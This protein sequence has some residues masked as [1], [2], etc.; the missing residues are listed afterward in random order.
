MANTKELQENLRPEYLRLYNVI[1][2]ENVNISP[3]FTVLP[4]RKDYPDYYDVIKKPIS[5]NTLKKRLTTYTNAQQFMDDLVHIPWNA[6]VYN[7]KESEIYKYALTLEKFINETVYPNL[8]KKY[9]KL[10][11][12]YLGPTPDEP[13]YQEFQEKLLIKEKEKQEE[14]E[15]KERLEK[16]AKS[17]KVLIRTRKTSNKEGYTTDS[18]DSNNE[19]HTETG[20]D[21]HYTDYGKGDDDDEYT[22]SG[23][24]YKQ[25]RVHAKFSP[26]P[27]GTPHPLGL[28]HSEKPVKK[29]V[30]RGRPPII[31][32]PYVQRMKNVLK[33]I[34]KEV[35]ERRRSL[36]DSFEK[37]P[38][39]NYNPQYYSI[40]SNPISL[41]EIRKKVKTRKYKDFE[42]FHNDIKL[43]LSNYRTYN[44]NNPN[45]LKRS[46][47]FEKSFNELAQFELSRPDT[48]YMPEGEFRC[49]LDE[50][51]VN[52]IT[53]QVGDWVL[54]KNRNDESKPIVGQI[55]KFWSEGTSGTKWL[56]AC[57][58]YRPEQ[59]VHRVDRLFYKTEVVK[60]GQYRDHKVS[61]IQGKCY[62]V[63]F[64]RYQRGDP[65]INIDGPLFVCEYRYN[66]SD[67]AFNKIRT[68]RAC[69]PEEIRDVEEQTIPVTGR[70][71]FKFPSPIRHLLPPNSTTRDP[72]PDPT[73]GVPNAPPI[74]GG[75]YMR[76]KLD[77]DDLGEYST[78]DDCPKHIIRPNDPK[79]RLEGKIDNDMGTIIVSGGMGNLARMTPSHTKLNTM[80]DNH[81]ENNYQFNNNESASLPFS[82]AKENVPIPN[83]NKTNRP[84]NISD[85][86]SRH[87]AQF[88]ANQRQREITHNLEAAKYSHATIADK[89]ANEASKH[90]RLGQQIVSLPH[91]YVLPLSITKNTGV[92]QTSD[93]SNQS[94]RQKEDALMP[95]K[96]TKEEILWF[97]G[98][99]VSINERLM[100][101]GIVRTLSMNTLT[102]S[103][104]DRLDYEEFEEVI[105]V[106]RKR[107]KRNTR[108]IIEQVEEEEF[109]KEEAQTTKKDEDDSVTQLFHTSLHSLRPSASFMSHRLAES[110]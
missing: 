110:T 1:N 75:V 29:Y 42:G 61:D 37:I 86:H 44:K 78:S 60:S 68:W 77:R 35:D 46:F 9:P 93:I 50:V 12:P 108:N 47:K 45:E 55:F 79:D 25:R 36:L 100:D 20:D 95:R 59:T 106:I 94:R 90:T 56:N 102:N 13:G 31:D 101:S 83:L 52:G 98:P 27:S 107:S 88:V 57:W 17:H 67:K 85:L 97:T 16:E 62:V 91:S 11:L 54:L 22:D 80:R 76:S 99:S 65:D 32:L 14:L 81:I 49:P 26:S 24:R 70:K 82:L 92:L 72:V 5:I 18:Y 19:V 23:R 64:T 30:K 96:R 34:R 71:F 51:I 40:I 38:D 109:D 6:K 4:P 104:K 33:V 7:T 63:H 66:E 74:V 53:Y 15:R 8:K 21:D 41:D 2:E 3:V 87:V 58:Y 10:E 84:L 43:M 39:R 28:R 48:D 105:P 89:I 69:L 103:S 73:L